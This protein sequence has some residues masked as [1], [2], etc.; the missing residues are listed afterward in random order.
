[1]PVSAVV[2]PDASFWSASVGAGSIIFQVPSCLRRS[3]VSFSAVTRTSS[4]L[5]AS[6]GKTFLRLDDGACRPARRPAVGIHEVDVRAQTAVHNDQQDRG[7]QSGACLP[8]PPPGIDAGRQHQTGN[9]KQRQQ[10]DPLMLVLGEV[11]RRSSASR[12][13]IAIRF[14][15]ARPS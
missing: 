4:I 7:L 8:P 15:S 5:S 1:M 9:D 11:I 6:T 13:R 12:G 10:H 3:V 2:S 14:R